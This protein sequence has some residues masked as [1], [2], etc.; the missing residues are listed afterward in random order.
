MYSP[1]AENDLK[2]SNLSKICTLYIPR[3]FV[4]CMP[5]ILLHLS[6]EKYK[7]QRIAWNKSLFSR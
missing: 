1:V 6:E 2:K 7:L 3:H 4:L 5:L